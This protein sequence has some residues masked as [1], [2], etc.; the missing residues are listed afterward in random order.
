MPHKTTRAHNAPA[1]N[2][3]VAR[4]PSAFIPTPEQQQIVKKYSINGNELKAVLSKH[5]S[6]QLEF[7]TFINV[8][9]VTISRYCSSGK[10]KIKYRYAQKLEE[11]VGT[12]LYITTIADCRNISKNTTEL[13]VKEDVST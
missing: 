13:S 8:K 1:H 11:F 3:P 6:S 4:E 12:A 10:R 5:G 7:A 2:T 9:Q